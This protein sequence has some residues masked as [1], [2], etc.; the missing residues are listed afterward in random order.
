MSWI[1]PA[2]QA[3]RP[4]GSALA[5]SRH[6]LH[7]GSC[8]STP[9]PSIRITPASI[10]GRLYILT[11]LADE[12]AE[13][14]RR[15]RVTPNCAVQAKV[16]KHQQT[17][18]APSQ[19]ALLRLDPKHSILPS[20][21]STT[22]R[23]GNSNQD[24]LKQKRAKRLGRL[25]VAL[26]SGSADAVWSAYLDLRHSNGAYQI[27]PYTDNTASDS[28]LTPDE[29][30]SVVKVVS[31]NA[32]RTKRGVNR[33]LKLMSDIRGEQRRLLAQL[34]HASDA[35]D[36][37]RSRIVKSELEEWDHVVSPKLLNA[38]ISHIGRSLRSVGLDEIDQMLDQLL[39]YEANEQSRRN[40]TH[41]DNFSSKHVSP[42]YSAGAM[43]HLRTAISS[44]TARS[45]LSKKRGK[46]RQPVF[47]DLAIYN[48]ILD[49]ITRTVHRSSTKRRSETE[50]AQ[51]YDEEEE[52]V[53]SKFA[54]EQLES[55][56]AEVHASLATKLRR[57]DLDA[58]AVPLHAD[59]FERAD[60]LFHSVLERM[61]RKSGI[62]P[63]A[64]TFNIMVTMYCLLD[65]WEMVH[66]VIRT[67]SDQGVLRIDCI[68]N[69]L[70][71]WLVRGPA[72]TNA[73]RKN[74]GLEINAIDS[75][76]EVYRQ[77]RQNLVHAELASQHSSISYG[78][79][80]T[81][82]QDAHGKDRDS[83]SSHD[84]LGPLAWPDRDEGPS[85]HSASSLSMPAKS[86]AVE[87]IL[88]IPRLPLEVMPDKIT[89]S[90][91]ISS[92]TREGRFADALSVFK[93]LVSTPVRPTGKD[94]DAGPN[95]PGTEERKM[96]PTLAIFDSFFQGFSRHGRPST[97][98]RFDAQDPESSTWELV[99]S[100]EPSE[101]DTGYASQV[102]EQ[103]SKD[104]PHA[105]QLQLWRIETFQEIF[106]AFLHF[107]PDVSQV[108]GQGAKHQGQGASSK[109]AERR[110]STP[111]GWLT[112]AEKRR[113][114]A[115]RRAPS[116]NQLF[117]IL[118]AIRRVSHDHAGWSLAMWQKVTDKF[119]PEA[120]TSSDAWTG[121]R[122][123]NR[124]SRVLDHLKAR[125]SQAQDADEASMT[126]DEA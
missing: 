55:H 40:A 63:D 112:L 32:V 47:P 43:D 29:F 53:M 42:L 70:G 39:T 91:M 82:A 126:E 7:P 69:A 25:H 62:E 102:E 18:K 10:S 16:R 101:A 1:V 6:S 115:L 59:A 109:R 113:L 34:Q 121:F 95:G 58:D 50:Q 84:T 98:T 100:S 97:S 74:E 31:N 103:Q 56:S 118:T 73:S 123:D 94:A 44:P 99:K 41:H 110:I 51:E 93:D 92:L 77:L 8:S 64:I 122:L 90:L 114:D 104:G 71:H 107:E 12:E 2:A 72:S 108:L 17:Q 46:Q 36:P 60:R 26:Q 125:L 88:G 61:Q 85:D 38:T 67:A 45:A 124:L 75:A 22:T 105:Q 76:L 86:G 9:R 68:N 30:R 87:A 33:I 106:D 66:R 54:E 48:T 57:F 28:V 49:I 52:D 23:D 13:Y 83:H 27:Y 116:T 14:A 78:R 80:E 65:Q 119:D 117:W 5:R 21:T 4:G 79:R 24:S 96:K 15:R 11:T 37:A 81:D 19:R 111:F 89:H 20:L 3:A 120:P 35:G